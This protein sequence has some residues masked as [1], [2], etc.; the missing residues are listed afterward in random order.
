MAHSSARCSG[1]LEVPG[2]NSGAAEMELNR[3]EAVHWLPQQRGMQTGQGPGQVAQSTVGDS[4]VAAQEAAR[5]GLGVSLLPTTLASRSGP[6]L[7][8]AVLISLLSQSHLP[9]LLV[10]RLGPWTRRQPLPQKR[11][12][13]GCQRRERQWGQGCSKGLTRE[14]CSRRMRPEALSM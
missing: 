11:V 9:H 13:Y 10:R 5:L 4:P 12:W 8:T 3:R 14:A 1:P 6:C 7:G 2:N